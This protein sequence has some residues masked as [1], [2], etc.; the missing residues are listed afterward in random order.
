MTVRLD[1]REDSPHLSLSTPDEVSRR[2]RPPLSISHI[3]LVLVAVTVSFPAAPI[4]RMCSDMDLSM[5][6]HIGH[7][8]KIDTR[9]IVDP[10]VTRVGVYV[11]LKMI[12]V[13]AMTKDIILC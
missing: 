2:F 10:M 12:D 4:P 7:A 8:T 9:T 1:E 13:S 6:T 11:E 5:S 3:P